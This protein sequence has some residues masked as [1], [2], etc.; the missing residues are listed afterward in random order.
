MA[1][2][3]GSAVFEDER[4]Q[5]R[6]KESHGNRASSHA[7]S[8]AG[9]YGLWKQTTMR[10]RARN[11]TFRSCLAK[12]LSQRDDSLRFGCRPIGQKLKQPDG[13]KIVRAI[14]RAMQALGIRK[15]A[16]R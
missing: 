5:A 13:A 8:S 15:G 7:R 1:G 12:I 4:D 6:S 16:R 10:A 11:E 9:V 14:I 2:C 3:R